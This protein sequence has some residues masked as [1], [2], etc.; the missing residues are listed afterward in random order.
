MAKKN[1]IYVE[2]E[3][4]GAT[5]TVDR[6]FGMNQYLLKMTYSRCTECLSKKGVTQK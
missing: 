4:C 2:C 5:G 1:K 6:P 3:N